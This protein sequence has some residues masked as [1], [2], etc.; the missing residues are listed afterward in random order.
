MPPNSS[1]LSW[2][3]MTQQHSKFK[4]F[5][6]HPTEGSPLGDVAQEVA[7]FVQNAGVAAKSIGTEYLEAKKSLVVTLGY[8]D[9]EPTY[10]VR[11]H[12]IKLAGPSQPGLDNLAAIETQMAEAAKGLS[13]IICHELFITD[14]G[15]FYMVFMVQTS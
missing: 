5:V 6:G 10:P 11:L 2:S 13:G 7:D 8:R 3:E 14:D 1:M 9:D 15:R 12:C 4:L